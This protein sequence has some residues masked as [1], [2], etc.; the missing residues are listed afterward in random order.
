VAIKLLKFGLISKD[1]I[2]TAIAGTTVFAIFPDI[3]KI[4]I[5]TALHAKTR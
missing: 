4:S 3:Q 5:E 1:A 2:K